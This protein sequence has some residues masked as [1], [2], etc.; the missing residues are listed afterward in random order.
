MIDKQVA[1]TPTPATRMA[2]RA[3]RLMHVDATE[4]IGLAD[5]ALAR[6]L[7]GDDRMGEAWARL[8]RG[9]YLLYFATPDEAGAELALAQQI[10]EVLGDR[11]GQLLTGAGVGRTLWRLGRV[12]E[13]LAHLLPLRD[14]GL[15]LLKHNQLG[16]LLNAIAGCH[17]VLGRSEEAFAYM[18]EALRCAGPKR[19]Y[20]FDAALYCNLSHELLQLGDYD[21]AL[22][23]ADH[24]ID[25]CQG[26]HNTRLLSVLRIN[27][28]ICLTALG[29]AVQAL[30][31]VQW[32]A[33]QVPDAGGRGTTT[34]HFESLA[35]AALRAGEDGLAKAL[36]AQARQHQTFMLPDER[37]EL[38]VVSALLAARESQPLAGLQHLHEVKAFVAGPPALA[39]KTASLRMRCMHAQTLSELY[40]LCGDTAAA[41]RAI[42]DWQSLHTVRALQASR[43]RYQAAVLQ[44]ELI[45]LQHK[46]E[47]T[48]ARRR[49]TERDRYELALANAQLSQ[50]IDQVE[51]LQKALRRQANQDVLTGLFNR[52]HLDEA[53]P[54]ALVR[55]ARPN[56]PLAI[57]VLDLDHFKQVNDSHG[58][59]VGDLVLAAFGQLLRDH[60]RRS[61]MAYRHGGEEFC[62]VMPNTDASAAANKMEL[63]LQR[64]REQVF[65][66]DTGALSG[67]TFSAGVTDTRQV[68]N[69]TAN[70]LLKAADALLL[71]AKRKGR[72]RVDTAELQ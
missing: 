55:K 40:E 13:A 21:Q 51:S 8:T 50:R 60:L 29:R 41:L 49:S 38:A 33:A 9:F 63:L 3:W 14:E 1:A 64:W 47:E 20:G 4:S 35:M 25:R 52:R 68:A 31:D 53:L 7:L 19:G 56:Q 59:Q 45:K 36:Q 48:D 44:T 69:G 12:E 61:D 23:Q 18:Y 24:G 57:V 70:A 34:L 17:S 43:A 11:P 15:R 10:F 28:V 30:P 46:L 2:R 26:R 37:V 39:D 65:E 66:I 32:I 6:A 22:T 5:R 67:L 71:A 58:H 62:I 72:N 54:A 16:V 42:R 27:R